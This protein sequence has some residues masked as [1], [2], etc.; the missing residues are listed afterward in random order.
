MYIYRTSLLSYAD[1]SFD[2]PQES[3]E[4]FPSVKRTMGKFLRPDSNKATKHIAAYSAPATSCTS[5]V[6]QP[7][8]KW[9][10]TLAKLNKRDEALSTETKKIDDKDTSLVESRAAKFGGTKKRTLRR[11]QSFQVGPRTTAVS[12]EK[13]TKHQLY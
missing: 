7:S 13:N 8:N 10:E 3:R 2:N 6:D 11:S 9:E 1:D 4:I 12:S 5:L